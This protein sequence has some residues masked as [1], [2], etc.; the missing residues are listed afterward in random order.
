[1]DKTGVGFLH[2][3][4]NVLVRYLCQETYSMKSQKVLTRFQPIRRA[5]APTLR[6]YLSSFLWPLIPERLHKLSAFPAH[7]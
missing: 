6:P 3:A 7:L 5:T 2:L 1:M 4:S